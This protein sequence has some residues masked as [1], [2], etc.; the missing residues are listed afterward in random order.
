MLIDAVKIKEPA[1]VLI[2]GVDA[3]HPNR[4][5]PTTLMVPLD[6]L[7]KQYLHNDETEKSA[8]ATTF[9]PS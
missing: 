9:L 8:G 7:E 6:H 5:G 1:N 4:H 2:T 3:L